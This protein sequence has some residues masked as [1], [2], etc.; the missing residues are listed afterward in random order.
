MKKYFKFVLVA[1][2]FLAIS[3]PAFAQNVDVN[4]SYSDRLQDVMDTVSRIEQEREENFRDHYSD[5]DNPFRS[6]RR[7]AGS[8]VGDVEWAGE[9]LVPDLE[10]YTVTNFIQALARESLARGGVDFSGTID[11]TINRINIGNHPVARISNGP[12][13]VSGTVVARDQSG[14]TVGEADITANI[15]VD[16]TV[17]Y[18]YKGPGFAFAPE[19]EN[20]RVGP[21]LVYF[22]RRAYS[23]IFP[24]HDFP[25]PVL[26]RLDRF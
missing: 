24:G 13:Y 2:G 16:F 10:N 18:S 11:I 14:N 15:V 17:D 8:L 12:T 9:Q 7:L 1:F 21:A 23:D 3:M 5:Q 26:V 20:T 25:R 19:H 6:N 22:M 4:V